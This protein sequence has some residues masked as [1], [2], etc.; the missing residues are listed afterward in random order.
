MPTNQGQGGHDMKTEIGTILDFTII[1]LNAL[2]FLAL[3]LQ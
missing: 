1:G 2:A 3:V